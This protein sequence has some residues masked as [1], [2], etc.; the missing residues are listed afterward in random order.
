MRCRETLEGKKKRIAE[1]H[2]RWLCL[3]RTKV[4]DGNI[5]AQIAIP[6]NIAFMVSSIIAGS[7]P[8]ERLF[9]LSKFVLLLVHSAS[10][11]QKALNVIQVDRCWPLKSA[12]KLSWGEPNNRASFTAT[13]CELALNR[14][15]VNVT[16]VTLK[17][18]FLCMWILLRFYHLLLLFWIWKRGEKEKKKRR[19][20]E[21]D[22]SGDRTY[23]NSA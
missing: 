3:T 8:A 15:G 23:G 21:G 4:T 18:S 2:L 1:L 13:K 17:R 12:R 5:S 22:K 9:F 19:E 6:K 11:F 14:A 10:L 7:N 16:K 20:R